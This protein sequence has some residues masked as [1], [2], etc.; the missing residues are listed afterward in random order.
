MKNS[1]NG[2]EYKLVSDIEAF[3]LDSFSPRLTLQQD[4]MIQLYKDML[5]IRYVE[6]Y[7]E[8]QYKKSNIRGFCHLTIGQEGLYAVLKDI[9]DHDCLITSY[10]CHGAAYAAG[11]NLKEII[12]ENLGTGEGN[13][14]GKGG[15]MHLYGDRFFGGHGIVG[16]QVPLGAGVAFALKYMAMNKTVTNEDNDF[17]AKSKESFLNA[18]TDNVCFCIFG[19][20]ATN[21]GQVYE[22]YNM[23]KV[24][25]LPIVFIVENNRYGMYTPLE[26]VTVDDCFFKRGYGIPGIRVRD[27][28]ISNLKGVLEFSKGY[29]MKCGPI[30]VQV[31]TFRKCGHSTLDL[32]KYYI[33][34]D[35]SEREAGLDCLLNLENEL[36]GKVPEQELKSIKEDAYLTVTQ[37]ANE[38]D[39]EN[40]PG[41]QELYS[42]IFFKNE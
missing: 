26:N 37:C 34:K 25:N 22:T 16:A 39:F 32:S 41:E 12:C 6:E 30:I 15:S 3:N 5:I 28:K 20:G 36:K 40:V 33:T 18:K 7:L 35:V 14:R 23:A 27:T 29:S 10:R 13:C 17:V 8:Q 31:D 4:N 24:Y 1:Q 9:I 2:M 19:D 21:Q 42:D 38:I 11:V